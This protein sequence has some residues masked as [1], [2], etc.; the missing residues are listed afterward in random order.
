MLI[1]RLGLLTGTSLIANLVL[2]TDVTATSLEQKEENESYLENNQTKLESSIE[3]SNLLKKI[4]KK[5]KKYPKKL[6]KNVTFD[7]VIE[8]VTLENKQNYLAPNLLSESIQFT[9]TNTQK[10]QSES[11][12]NLDSQIEYDTNLPLEYSITEDSPIQGQNLNPILT[13]IEEYSQLNSS[14]EPFPRVDSLRDVKPEDWAY[15]ALLNLINNYRCLSG[16]EDNN[17]RG[18]RAISRYEFA[19]AL[20]SCL[21][22]MV[23]LIPDNLPSQEDIAK[24]QR[25]QQEFADEL[26]ATQTKV[27]NL[28]ALVYFLEEHNFSSTTILRGRVDFSITSLFGARKAAPSGERSTEDLDSVA[29]FAGRARLDFDTS[30]TGKDLL[31]TRLE[32][33]NINGLGRRFTGTTMTLLGNATNTANNIRIGKLFYRFPIGDSGMVYIATARQSASDFV[34][35]LNPASTISLFGFNNP[36]YDQGFG[37]GGGIYYQFN[38]VI[39]TGV[40]Y[41][42]GTNASNPE[43]GK[44]FFNGYFTVLSQ[45]TITP[46]D[47]L[48]FVLSYA[49]YYSPEP[50]STN[51]ITS[52]VGSRFAQLPFGGNT[53]TSSD[54]FNLAGSYRINEHIEIGGWLGYFHAVAKSSPS[55]SGFN[56]PQGSDADIWAWAFTASVFD[57]GKLGSSLNFILGMPPKLTNNDISERQDRGTSLHIELSYKYP[58]T[59]RIFIGP[60]FFVITNPEHNSKNKPIWVGELRTTFTF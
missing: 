5:A 23:R 51:N 21:Q 13:Q 2:A 46:S 39:G 30:F 6:S 44:G 48:G 8:R 18:N 19:A 17:F 37:A 22:K 11:P 57:V 14:F 31:R 24:V 45:V 43:S 29:T 20:N 52:F 36:I 41:Y 60:G 50:G 3:D 12:I 7:S 26:A 32:G 47:R 59:D 10:K 27:D 53:A 15:D 1:K 49:H 34:P 42:T 54:S 9:N 35:T 58:I 16:F 55:N 25:L 33:G 38:D 56:A 4:N 40:T 28:E